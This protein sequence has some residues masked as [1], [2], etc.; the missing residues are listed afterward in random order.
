MWPTFFDMENLDLSQDNGFTLGALADSL[1]E[2]LPK[3]YALLGGLEP[4]YEKLYRDAMETVTK[5][6]VFLPIVFDQVDILFSRSAYVAEN[7]MRTPPE[8]I[9]RIDPLFSLFANAL[10]SDSLQTFELLSCSTLEACEWDEKEWQEKGG[11]A[12]KKGFQNVRDPR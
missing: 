8:I 5:Y 6:V 2:M 9:F 4:V 10:V 11:H 3:M 7:S 1:Y 12:L